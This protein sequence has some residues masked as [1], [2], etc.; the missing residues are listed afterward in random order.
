MV[1]FTKQEEL[2]RV[3]NVT[4]ERKGLSYKWTVN[5]TGLRSPNKN[6]GQELYI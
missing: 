2:L 6:K 3:T 5:K 4:G 1:L